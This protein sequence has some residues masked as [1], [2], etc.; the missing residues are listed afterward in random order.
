MSAR[1]GCPGR[2]SPTPAA[3]CEPS[4]S[5]RPTCRSRPRVARARRRPVALFMP[6]VT[7]ASD[8]TGM[9]GSMPPCQRAHCPSRSGVLHGAAHAVL[10]VP[11][12]AVGHRDGVDVRVDELRVPGHRIGDAVDV[13]P[14]AGVEADE[15][16]AEGGA[17][18]HQLEARFDLLDEHVHLDRADRKPKVLFERRKDVVPQRRFFGRLDLRQVQRQRRAGRPQLSM[19]VDDV[20]RR[21]DDGGG[22]AGAVGMCDVAIVEVQPP[23]AKDLRREVELSR[24]VVDRSA[25]RRSPAPTDSFRRRPVRQPSRN[26]GSR[27]MASFRFR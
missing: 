8:P 27:W 20:E 11:H 22:E 6:L 17:D 24:P 26:T 23:R 10:V 21:V 13:I 3:R 19:V 7:P 25:G 18:L 1:A 5:E 16:R 4:S 12:V 14:A 15:V 2:L 9:F